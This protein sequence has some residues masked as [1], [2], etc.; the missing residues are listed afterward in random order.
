MIVNTVWRFYIKFLLDFRNSGWI[1]VIFCEIFNECEN[2][3]YSVRLHSHVSDTKL[4]IVETSALVL[5][6]SVNDLSKQN[7][8]RFIIGAARRD[9]G[10]AFQTDSGGLCDVLKAD[11]VSAV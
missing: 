3:K 10:S 5:I 9:L 7:I 11:R 2:G 6:T 1:T 4:F 8:R